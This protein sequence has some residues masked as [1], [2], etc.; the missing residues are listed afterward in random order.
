[1]LIAYAAT[2]N[3]YYK[4]I[5]AMRSLLEFNDAE[6][7][8]LAEDDALPFDIPCR[9][10]NVDGRSPFNETN[11]RTPF[12]YMSLMRLLLP[13]LIPEDKVLYLDVDTIVQ[14]DLSKLWGL[15]MGDRWWAAVEESYGRWKPFGRYYFNAGVSLF[16]LDQLRKDNI[17]PRL[18]DDLNVCTYP[19]PDQDVLNKYAV[20]NKVLP[21][22]TRF[23]ECFAT[24][25]T[26]NP[27][28]IHYAG[29]QDWYEN[30]FL[31][32]HEVLEK[33]IPPC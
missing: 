33:Y 26:G 1:M 14:D 24:G 30:K 23:N 4:M 29:F 3:I 27:A 13:D 32:R 16:N 28:V 21:L 20:P 12:S 9:V 6:I 2:R 31:F 8:V 17:V 7:V 5:P 10:I 22:A 18:I 25:Y 11:S 15:P 19:Y